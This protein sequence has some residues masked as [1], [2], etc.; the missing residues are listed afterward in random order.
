VKNVTKN[1]LVIGSS[2]VDQVIFSDHLPKPGETVSGGKFMQVFGGKGANQA[3]AASKAGG[4]VTMLTSIGDDNFGSEII[5]NYKQFGVGTEFAKRQTGFHTGIALIMV[6]SK[7]ENCISVALG[8]NNLLSFEMVKAAFSNP[9]TDYA[10]ALLQMEAPIETVSKSIE[11]LFEKGIPVVLN[12][13]PFYNLPI[14]V[15]G[16]VGYLVLN[17]SEVESLSKVPVSNKI[18]AQTAA[19]VIFDQTE[20]P[21]IIITLGGEG[22]LLCKNGVLS[23]YTVPKVE[24]VDTTAAGDVFCGFLTTWLSNGMPIEEAIEEAI[25]AAAISVTKAGAQPSIPTPDEMDLLKK[26]GFNSSVL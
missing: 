17:N 11:Y 6:D 14:S 19:K 16:K 20:I 1:I 9:D 22:V 15:L 4:N 21:N 24:V 23:F 13:A 26:I 10:I 3:V 7:G 2:N 18:D 12:L 5:W 25:F 8:A